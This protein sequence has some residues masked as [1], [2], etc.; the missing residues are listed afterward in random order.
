ME[1]DPPYLL[2]NGEGPGGPGVS[3]TGDVDTAMIEMDVRGRWNS[4]LGMAAYAAFCKCLAEHPA[5]IIV[6]LSGLRDP[7]GAS[8]PMWLASC[9]RATAMQPP[10]R[11]ALT[12][13][14]DTPLADRLGRIGANLIPAYR[15]TEEARAAVA[16][17]TPYTDRLQSAG[18][19][20]DPA[21]VR[22]ARGV[23]DTACDAWD[24]PELR[25]PGR[26]VITE[27]VANAV[28]YARTDMVV[29]VWRRGTG[30]HLSVRDGDPRMPF[31]R[32]PRSADASASIQR[33]GH[34][35]RIVDAISSAWGAMATGDGKKVWAT[36]D[37]CRRRWPLRVRE[38]LTG[39]MAHDFRLPDRADRLS[40]RRSPRV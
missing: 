31:L 29:T 16:G 9:Q 19:P 15:T 28:E 21:A 10:V 22:T 2:D 18:L 8:A 24:F 4:R 6:N 1:E 35:L 39:S 26:L 34:G 5:A 27:L 23:V 7:T 36:V 32:D 40:A 30:L 3:V 17:R 38:T 14:S 13:P 11:M 20:P 37:S 33:R 12:L 25:Y